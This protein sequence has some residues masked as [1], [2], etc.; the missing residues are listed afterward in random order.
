MSSPPQNPWPAVLPWLIAG[1]AL[2]TVAA[3]GGFGAAYLL[4]TGQ[5]VATVDPAKL[6][7]PTPAPTPTPG[8]AT[9]S[10]SPTPVSTATTSSPS[11]PASA[12]PA[13]SASPTEPSG[14]SPSPIR[15][16]VKRG[17]RLANIADQFGVTV[18]AIVQFNNLDNPDHIEAGQVLLI[19]LP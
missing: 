12:S 3:V 14:P 16:L 11:G 8:P 15:Y 17:D 2:F 6:P 9:P 5:A 19:P 13:A 4:S 10:P 18:D 1:I 7:T